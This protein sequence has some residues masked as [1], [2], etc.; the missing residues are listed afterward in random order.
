LPAADLVTFRRRVPYVPKA[1]GADERSFLGGPLTTIAVSQEFADAL[2]ATAD[3]DTVEELIRFEWHAAP[4]Q[5]GPGYTR[6]DVFTARETARFYL[7]GLRG[8]VVTSRPIDPVDTDLGGRQHVTGHG[9][10]H[11]IRQRRK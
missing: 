10:R 6:E 4:A 1:A 3:I 8:T 2:K 5:F 11:I 9:A 7:D